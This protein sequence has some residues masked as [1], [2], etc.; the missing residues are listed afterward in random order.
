MS[1]STSCKSKQRLVAEALKYQ[2]VCIVKAI[3]L[4]TAFFW[5]P[6][7]LLCPKHTL[8][9]AK[10]LGL[11]IKSLKVD[12]IKERI[13]EIWANK[14]IVKFDVLFINNLDWWQATTVIFA[15]LSGKNIKK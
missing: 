1:V 14:I 8:N 4:A 2:L 11:K 15:Q 10:K 7:F 3:T 12:L 6:N 13:G 9:L 5:D